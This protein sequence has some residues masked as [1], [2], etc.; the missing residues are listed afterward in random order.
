VVVGQLL[1]FNDVVEVRPHQVGHKVPVNINNRVTMLASAEPH[2]LLFRT[3]DA[4]GGGLRLL[5]INWIIDSSFFF[6][7]IWKDKLHIV[8]YKK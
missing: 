5:N 3:E 1:A 6:S 7:I 2:W 4:R 8:I